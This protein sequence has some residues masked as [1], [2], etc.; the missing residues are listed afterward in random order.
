MAMVLEAVTI[1]PSH[2]ADAVVIWLHGLGADGYDFV[3]AIPSL[4]LGKDHTIRFIF[5]HAPNLPVTLNNKFVMPAWYDIVAIDLNA[6]QDEKGIRT[7]EEALK[8]L[9]DNDIKRGIAPSRI[10][11]V[12]FS[13]GGAL[14][15]H[16]ALRFEQPLAGVGLLSSY[17]PLHALVKQERHTQ[18]AHIPIF[19]A[20]GTMDDIVPYAMGQR[21]YDYLKALDYEPIWHSYAMAHAVCDLEL[22]D[23][24]KWIQQCLHGSLSD[25]Q[26]YQKPSRI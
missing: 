22:K 9:I 12:G 24:G 8:K 4:G 15:I 1:E 26:D 20:H 7:S 13:Q 18:N 16:T 5:P 10:I 11:L 23:I 14:A 21:S 25:S 6:P 17:L 19:I 3:E 2:K